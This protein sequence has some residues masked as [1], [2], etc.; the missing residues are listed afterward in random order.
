MIVAANFKTN[1]TRAST[2]T[3]LHA[4]NDFLSTSNNNADVYVF[5]TAT[6]LDNHETHANISIGVQNAYHTTSGSHTGEIG[7]EQLDEFNIKTI[8]IGH[9]E[10][11]AL[12]EDEAE[13]EKKFHFFSK[14]GYKIIYCIGESKEIRDQGI[15]AVKEYLFSQ[16]ESI[17]PLYHNLIIAYEPI[18]A[19]GTG[20]SATVE[21]IDETL[22]YLRTQ[23][24]TPLL[25]GG[26]VKP[27]NADEIYSIKNCDGVLVGTA[28]WDVE[29]FKEMI[30][31]SNNH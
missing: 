14:L 4:L 24:H 8:L 11:R 20:V 29:S 28:S 12:G 1:H 9:S 22:N 21:Q 17:D 25:Y 16:L 19:I 6:A 23:V 3:Y 5:P 15:G 31:L 27:L 2:K 18:W 10:R 13:L 26:S 7:T 30:K